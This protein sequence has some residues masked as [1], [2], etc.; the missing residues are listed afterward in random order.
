MGKVIEV[1]PAAEVE[2]PL[3]GHH[4]ELKALSV[5]LR[6]RRSR[7]IL[8][9]PGAG[10]TRLNREAIG[11]APEAFVMVGRPGPLHNFLVKCA[12]QLNCRRKHHPAVD[13]VPSIALKPP[14]IGSLRETPRCVVIEDLADA[15]PRMYRFLQELYYVPGVCLIVSATT[16]GSLG[17]MRKLLWDPR[18]EISLGPLSRSESQC[19][20]DAAA[21]RFG[22]GTLDVEDFR[23]R[24][25]LAAGGN[26]GQ[27]VSM[28]RFAARSEYQAGRHIKFLPLCIDVLPGMCDE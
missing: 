1:R 18:E 23:R 8:G 14:V 11:V 10:K 9:P 24:V 2:L 15:D 20:F 19:L 26:P 13:R 22:L 27:I 21:D 5:A 6:D 16:R 25:L 3:I 4:N 12:K 17:F 28:C 7:L